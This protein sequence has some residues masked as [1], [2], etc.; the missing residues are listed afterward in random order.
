MVGDFQFITNN[1]QCFCKPTKVS[2]NN[3]ART[4]V[5]CVYLIFYLPKIVVMKWLAH[6]IEQREVNYESNLFLYVWFHTYISTLPKE[7]CSFICCFFSFS[8]IVGVSTWC[9]QPPP[10]PLL[11]PRIVGAL[12][13]NSFPL[14]LHELKLLWYMYQIRWPKNASI[15]N[16]CRIKKP[17]QIALCN[18]HVFFCVYNKIIIKFENIYLWFHF[19]LWQGGPTISFTMLTSPSQL[20]MM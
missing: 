8:Q 11:N 5:I 19:S 13:V 2:I 20:I 12:V 18:P 15:F 16:T 1:W 10:L 17:F 9:T 3:E 14:L 6:Q 7:R 4:I